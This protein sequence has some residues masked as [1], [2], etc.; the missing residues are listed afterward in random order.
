MNASMMYRAYMNGHSMTASY[1]GYV[2]VRADD[3]QDAEY[4]AKRELTGLVGTFSDW[5]PSMFQV[6]K[7][8]CIGG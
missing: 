5:S 2:D 1:S 6:T 4:R 8:E 7:I 3:E